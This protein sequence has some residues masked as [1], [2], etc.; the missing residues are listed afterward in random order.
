[1]SI[2]RGTRDVLLDGEVIRLT[3][4]LLGRAFEDRNGIDFY[5]QLH[6]EDRKR[7]EA[8]HA[9]LASGEPVSLAYRVRTGRDEYVS[10]HAVSEPM[11]SETDD[12]LGIVTIWQPGN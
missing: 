11:L 6:P 8:R 5:E 1:M 2:N 3:R 12:L 9:I 10:V 4:Q 7:V